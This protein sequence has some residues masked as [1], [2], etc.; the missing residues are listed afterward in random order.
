MGNLSDHYEFEL[1]SDEELRQEVAQHQ[2]KG[3][4]KKNYYKIKV[5]KNVLRIFPKMKGESWQ[6]T[7]SMHYVPGP[8]GKTKIFPCP[9]LELKEPCPACTQAFEL[10]KSRNE[11]DQELAKKWFPKARTF[12][13]VI[14]RT[15]PEL[16]PQVFAF[17]QD[18]F[19]QIQTI[20]N[21]SDLGGRS[22]LRHDDLGR[23][24]VLIRTGTGQFDTVYTV[25]ASHDQSPFASDLDEGSDWLESREDLTEFQVV[26]AFDKIQKML[27]GG[28]GGGHSGGGGAQAASSGRK[29]SVGR[30]SSGALP[31]GGSAAAP[32]TG[33]VKISVK[34]RVEAQGTE[35]TNDSG[36][37][38]E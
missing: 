1:P 12:C 11:G 32:R 2:A 3:S 27:T 20:L 8:D 34:R 7:V 6:I 38:D 13:N 18:I 23:D 15:A 25:T 36:Y 37:G 33:G 10:H 19:G 35:S 4:A 30:P 26:P 16:G 22:I 17:G 21:D 29:V 5:G 9:R 31:S 24:L 14:D 28:R